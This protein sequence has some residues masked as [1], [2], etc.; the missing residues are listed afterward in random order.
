[1][2]KNKNVFYF[3]RVYPHGGILYNTFTQ[4]SGKRLIFF[5][6]RAIIK[7]MKTV[8][9][10]KNLINGEKRELFAAFRALLLEYNEKYNLT[11]ILE[12]RYGI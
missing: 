5:L 3:H 6:K 7:P 1:M 11:T 12:E 10:Y 9:F 4:S 2:Y 8:E